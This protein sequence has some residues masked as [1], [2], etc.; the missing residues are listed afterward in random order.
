MSAVTVE[1]N[2]WLLRIRTASCKHY[3]AVTSK[4][5]LLAIVLLIFRI[6]INDIEA[7]DNIAKTIT[8][9]VG[10]NIYSIFKKAADSELALAC[11]VWF[12]YESVR[13]LAKVLTS[14]YAGVTMC[15]VPAKHFLCRRLQ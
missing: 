10:D 9:R 4:V 2:L 15:W 6:H 12:Y 7:E 14:S 8:V 3:H 11:C 1:Y 13:V 5:C